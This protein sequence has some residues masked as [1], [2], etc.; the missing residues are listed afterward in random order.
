MTL[1]HYPETNPV[2]FS[3]G[4]ITTNWYGLWFE[5]GFLV[6]TLY[7]VWLCR[8]NSPPVRADQMKALVFFGFVTVLAGSRSGYFLSQPAY[9]FSADP[10]AV[11][12]FWEGGTSFYGG[13]AAA[14]LFLAGYARLKKID[15]FRL[16]DSVAPL[17]FITAMSAAAGDMS[18]G[19]HWGS[20]SLSVPWAV[21]FPLSGCQD[22]L[23]ASVCPLYR[24]WLQ[25]H[26]YS[27]LPRHP[28]QIYEFILGCIFTLVIGLTARFRISRPGF[29]TGQ[30]LILAGLYKGIT[31]VVYAEAVPV[32][33][34]LQLLAATGSSGVG[35]ILMLRNR[36]SEKMLCV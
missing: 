24:E 34:V 10:F 20:V 32:D 21:L 15:W 31:L 29:I 5:A 27:V 12:R 13:L 19:V 11:L 28:L 18:N 17:G 2:I 4:P 30:F 3:L 9:L 6:A 7:S 33:G 35:L 36:R 23:L 22:A 14:G 1:F 8:K 26:E 25:V 16:T